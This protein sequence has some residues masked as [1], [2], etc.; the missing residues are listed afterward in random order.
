[1]STNSVVFDTIA[2]EGFR[3]GRLRLLKKKRVKLT[4]HKKVKIKKVKVKDELV[5]LA[6]EDIRTAEL[7]I[8]FLRLD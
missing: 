8:I 1:M 5:K 4:V 3:V 2:V 6:T 7:E